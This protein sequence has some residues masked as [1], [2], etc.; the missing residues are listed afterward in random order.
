MFFFFESTIHPDGNGQ[1]TASHIINLCP[2]YSLVTHMY[3]CRDAPRFFM[4]FTAWYIVHTAFLLRTIMRNVIPIPVFFH[5]PDYYFS[6][7]DTRKE[8]DS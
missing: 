5:I 6:S 8:K 1:R 3:I 2:H 4:L 7:Y